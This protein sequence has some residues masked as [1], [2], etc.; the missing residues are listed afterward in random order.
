VSSPPAAGSLDAAAVRRVWDEVLAVVRRRSQRSWALVREASVRDVH[1]DEVV[2]VFQHAAHAT[3]FSAQAELLGEALRELLGGTWRVR[4]ELGGE[5]G[6][7]R[8]AGGTGRTA[9]APRPAPA[10]APPRAAASSAPAPTRPAPADDGGWPETARPG[11]VDA[12]P[13]R[14]AEPER[15]ASRGK[16]PAAPARPAKAAPARGRP[17][18]AAR[19]RDSGPPPDEPPFDPDYDRPP[20]GPGG[21]EGFDPGDEPLDDAN[22]VRVSSEEQAKQAL[23]AQF[24]VE[25]IGDSNPRP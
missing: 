12:P 18:P 13:P 6:G 11:G 10:A 7:Q 5:A 17:A 14:P 19:G 2:L 16:A 23:S 20:A 1:G 25:K 22:S 4:A 3:M 24:I 9:A 8:P 21:Y 15:P